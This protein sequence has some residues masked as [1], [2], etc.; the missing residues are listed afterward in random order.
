MTAKTRLEYHERSD[1]V[2]KPA[3]NATDTVIVGYMGLMTASD[4]KE[5]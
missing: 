1:V 3:F 4:P 5:N 2:G